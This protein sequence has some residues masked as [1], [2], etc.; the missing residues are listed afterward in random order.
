MAGIA[1]ALL[2]PVEIGGS[3]GA[4]LSLRA[5]PRPAEVARVQL[6][7]RA[8]S[9]VPAIRACAGALPRCHTG[10]LA[11][12]PSLAR[13]RHGTRSPAPLVPSTTQKRGASAGHQLQGSSCPCT[14]AA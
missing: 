7:S 10:F 1:A 11:N 2:V 8:C 12:T 5:P 9:V 3:V 4:E 6:P 14:L 13:C